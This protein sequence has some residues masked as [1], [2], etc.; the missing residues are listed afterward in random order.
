M[1]VDHE[2]LDD[3]A[4]RALGP[5]G[6]SPHR[7]TPHPRLARP[8]GLTAFPPPQRPRIVRESS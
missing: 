8:P 2:C 3:G 1:D 4:A 5:P 6:L 7:K